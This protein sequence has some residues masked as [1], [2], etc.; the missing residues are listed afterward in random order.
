MYRDIL[1]HGSL[2][3]FQKLM[4]FVL[5]YIYILNKNEK[6]S[7]LFL[8]SIFQTTTTLIYQFEYILHNY[9]GYSSKNNEMVLYNNFK[10]EYIHYKKEKNINKH[11]LGNNFN[12]NISIVYDVNYSSE[13]SI[14]KYNINFS[15]K[16]NDRI[17]LTGITGTGKSTLCKIICGHFNNF[18][19]SISEQILYINQQNYINYK[20][21][22]LLNI[23]TQNDFNINYVNNIILDD[24]FNNLINIDDIKNSFTEKN[25]YLNI[26]LN[27]NV[28]SGGQE[29][30]LYL[31]MWIYHLIIN[32]NKYKIL[33]LDEPDKG[34]DYDTFYNII[35]NICNYDLFN[36]LSIIIVT[37][38]YKIIEK[39]CN[40][41]IEI[42]NNNNNITNIYI[43]NM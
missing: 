25:N 40:K 22:T 26:K 3:L 9:Y 43:K 29:K 23:I 7:N 13:R 14:L 39:L 24:I 30:R 33:I 16:N 1:Y 10:K 18:D 5:F 41:N 35:Y 42:L 4:F 31:I 32:I 38:N 12:Y 28:L 21:R 8:L 20:Y 15:I 37:H 6:K 36:N 19:L 17:I 34:L 27:D 11:I 2:G